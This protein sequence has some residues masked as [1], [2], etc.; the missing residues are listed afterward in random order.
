MPR[1]HHKKK[2]HKRNWKWL[3]ISLGALGVVMVGIFLFNSQAA[4][5]A[6]LIPAQAYAKYQDG[7]FFL[8]VRSQE[9][10]DQ[11]HILGST[12]IPLELLQGN[13]IDLPREADIVVVCLSGRRSQSG[14]DLL[15]QAGFEHIYCLQGGIQA[16]M[17]AGYPVQ[18]GTE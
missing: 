11:L 18:L 7:A 17:D 2:H 14:T 8:D 15:K 16:W 9:E 4:P 6:D 5:S 1:K 13:L 3:W 10:F 12:L